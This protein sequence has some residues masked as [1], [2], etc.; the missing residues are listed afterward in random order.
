MNRGSPPRARGKAIFFI[1]GLNV[2]L[3][4]PRVR[5]EKPTYGRIGKTVWGSPPRA[6]GKVLMFQFGI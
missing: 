6:R 2:S 3:D 5:G 4:H 1:I